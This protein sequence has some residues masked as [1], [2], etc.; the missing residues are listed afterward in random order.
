MSYGKP[1]GEIRVV[2]PKPE[3]SYAAKWDEVYGVALPP[4]PLGIYSFYSRRGSDYFPVDELPCWCGDEK[5][6]L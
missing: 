3:F 2:A 4:A 5:V 1:E 6:S